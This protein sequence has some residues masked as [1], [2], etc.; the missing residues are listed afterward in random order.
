[1]HYLVSILAGLIL[2]FPV[3]TIAAVEGQTYKVD[4]NHTQVL[5]KVSHL[6]FSHVYGMFNDMTGSFTI[7]EKEMAKSKITVEIDVASV[8]TLHKDRDEH[9]RKA[10]F[11]D[12]KKYPKMIFKSTKVIK[13]RANSYQVTG[14]LTLHGKTKPLS[15]VFNRMK[16]GKDHRGKIRTGG[17]AQFKIKRTD[18]G[19][20]Y[21]AKPGQIGD[22]VDVILTLEGI[23]QSN[24]KSP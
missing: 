5:F 14:N 16:T 13:K 17:T 21:M 18:F 7:D 19:M 12:V 3:L 6:G 20:N 24:C 2:I 8:N 9:L 10:D 22:E 1:M 23:C 15:F 11:F 4:K